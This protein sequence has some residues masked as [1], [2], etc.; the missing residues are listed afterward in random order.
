MRKRR[1]KGE[2]TV[3]QRKDGRWEASFYLENGKRS[4]SVYGRTQ[5]EALQKLRAMQH[6]EKQGTLVTSPRQTLKQYLEHWLEN[7]HKSKI[8]TSTYAGY[9]VI[10][11]KHIIPALGDF[12]VQK[13][14]AQQVED[15]YASKL[16]E[17]L[18]PGYV[19]NMHTVL[20]KAMSH[21]VRINL[22]ARN[23]CDVVEVP[24]P[25]RDEM[26]PLTKEQAQ[27][28]LEMAKERRLETLL[29]VAIT[30]GM[31]RG[32]M[33]GLRWQDIDF[34]NRSLQVRRT[35]NR[36]TGHGF[37]ENE[38]KTAKGRRKIALPDVVVEALKQHRTR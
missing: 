12:P 23:V 22:V 36:I 5:R 1:G 19:R 33:L 34:E 6:E 21:A 20:H 28:L 24:H 17:G 14:T 16:R 4:R 29:I 25:R 37:V 35:V 10:L 11:D 18:K 3:F 8:R 9:R 27:K 31:R 7:V 13:L 2:G 38:P 15:F 32:E 30:T 26:K